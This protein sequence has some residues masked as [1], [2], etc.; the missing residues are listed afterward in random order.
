MSASLPIFYDPR[1][2]RA[3]LVTSFVLVLSTIIVAIYSVGLWGLAVQPR[4]SHPLTSVPLPD[5]STSRFISFHTP[6]VFKPHARRFPV[7][8]NAGSQLAQISLQQHLGQIS[9]LLPDWLTVP[10]DSSQISETNPQDEEF[11]KKTI[12]ATGIRLEPLLSDTG[13][14]GLD[15]VL[16][17]PV[18]RQALVNQLI[19]LSKS[20]GWSG[21][22]ISFDQ[23]AN[24]A[25]QSA[26]VQLFKILESMDPGLSRNLVQPASSEDGQPDLEDLATHVFITEYDQHWLTSEPGPVAAVDW[27]KQ[28]VVNRMGQANSQKYIFVLANY[29]YDWQVNG[30]S[31]PLDFQGV[32]DKLSESKALPTFD[33]VSANQEA[34]YTDSHGSMHE[35]WYADAVSLRAQL[36]TLQKLPIALWEVGSED[37]TSWSVLDNPDTET[38]SSVQ[39]SYDLR[40]QGQGDSTQVTAQSNPGQRKFTFAADGTVTSLRT[41]SLPSS[42]RVDRSGQTNSKKIALTFDDGPDPHYTPQIL[43]ILDRYEVPATF[44]VI[45]SNAVRNPDLVNRAYLEGNEVGNHTYYHSNVAVIS[46]TQ[47]RLELSLTERV[48][49]SIT[50][51]KSSFFRP[52]YAIDGDPETAQ[53]LRPLALVSQLGYQTINSSID[54][55]DWK[56]NRKAVDIAQSV[57]RSAQKTNGQIILLHDGGGNREQTVRALPSIISG[58][59]A[60]GYQ[61][62]S[63][64]DLLGAT[65]DE[66]MPPVSKLELWTGRI[67][68]LGYQITNLFQ[69]LIYLLFILSISLGLVRLLGIA[70]LA[71]LQHRSV[72]PKGVSDFLP[73]VAI[74]IPAFN[75]ETVIVRTVKA[76]LATKYP[77][78]TVFVIDDGSTDSTFEVLEKDFA[79]LQN[80]QLVRQENAGKA[81]ALNRAI[82]QIQA[83]IIVTIDA[84]TLIDP[85]AVAQ[86]VPHFHNP[87]VVA[88]AGNAKVGNRANLLT[89]WQALEYIMGQ[90]LDRR[91][92]AWLNCICV[93]P[94]AIGAWR[95]AAILTAGG[96]CDDTLAEDTDLTLELLERGGTITYADQ[97]YAYTEAPETV[98]SFIKQRFRWVF[99]TLQ[100]IWK[101]R[102]VLLRK[103]YHA[104]GL[105]AVPNMLLFQISLPLLGPLMDFLMLQ[106]ILATLIQRA[107]HPESY[108]PDS[109]QKIGIYYLLFLSLEIVAGLIAFYLERQEDWRLLLWV[110]VQRF[111][112]RQIL[113]F[114]VIRSVNGAVMGRAVGWNKFARSGKVKINTS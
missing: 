1:R 30:P 79:S 16:E 63:V 70:S 114:S 81:A 15:Q 80:I 111:F 106:S 38:L 76:A 28:T 104:L 108:S 34:K 66:S 43:D 91:A 93:V 77:N 21:I 101:H 39:Y 37:P 4:I 95:L 17:Q 14:S 29:G 84:D 110:P 60:A 19:Q 82:G 18:L 5:P 65:R 27:V 105:V 24:Q 10:R 112:Y 62:V 3:K 85:E 113:Y 40:Y 88:V 33:P 47:L 89:R 26:R 67:N 86:L 100:A 90:N 20:R 57:I 23:T 6:A 44:F 50:G 78:L 64:S 32:M 56:P 109:V 12:S 49:E 35:I 13:D 2:K 11:V 97:A 58:L 94:G 55:S 59:K 71:V 92:F 53:Q 72:R 36:R 98:A 8:Y 7:F 45:G 25:Q 61:L 69:D 48:I 74:V 54:P 22:S 103:K 52:P 46:A 42:L 96:F 102:Q 83:E 73:T 99:G 107:Q 41:L 68:Y 75:E 87:E 9:T 51:H 31:T